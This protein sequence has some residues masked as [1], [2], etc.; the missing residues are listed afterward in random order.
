M[1]KIKP[2]NNPKFPPRQRMMPRTIL[3]KRTIIPPSQIPRR[4][5]A[6]ASRP[7]K[8]IDDVLKKLKEM[9]K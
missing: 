2:D 5:S 1:S 6:P 3:P 8:E 7:V 9:G 4:Q